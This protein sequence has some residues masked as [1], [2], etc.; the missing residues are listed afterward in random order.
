M[1]M[2]KPEARKVIKSGEEIKNAG[3]V[4]ELTGIE[5]TEGGYLLNG[6]AKS[7]SA[8]SSIG[9]VVTVFMAENKFRFALGHN[10][11]R[12]LKDSVALDEDGNRKRK[13]DW[14]AGSEIVLSGCYLKGDRLMAKGGAVGTYCVGGNVDSRRA[15]TTAVAGRP[16]I[17][18]RNGDDAYTFP[19]VAHANDLEPVVVR[20]SEKGKFSNCEFSIDDLADGL[21]SKVVEHTANIKAQLDGKGFIVPVLKVTLPVYS[22]RDAYPVESADRLKGQTGYVMLIAENGKSE[23]YYLS[24]LAKYSAEENAKNLANTLDRAAKFVANNGPVQGV[25]Y[26]LVQYDKSKALDLCQAYA[27]YLGALNASPV[28]TYQERWA[29]WEKELSAFN[30]LGKKFTESTLIMTTYKDKETKAPRFNLERVVPIAN[31]SSDAMPMIHFNGV[32]PVANSAPEVDDSIDVGGMDVGVSDMD[33]DPA[34]A[35]ALGD[36][37]NPAAPARRPR[38]ATLAM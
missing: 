36:P 12:S 23:T 6:M 29:S 31:L 17:E 11:S 2:F 10:L 25:P 35:D 19:M 24:D 16:V 15:I 22:P 7:D 20:V 28:Q 4:M 21:R 18:M 14:H 26:Y 27:N 33:I 3:F 38:N 8:V 30:N 13:A 5:L 1:N 32:A 37:V 34:L 9:E